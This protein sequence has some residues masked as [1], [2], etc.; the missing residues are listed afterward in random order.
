VFPVQLPNLYKG[1]QL[2]VVGRYQQ[3]DSGQVTLSG[4]NQI[5]AQQYAYPLVL[6]DSFIEGN[7][8]LVKLWAKK[9]IES[10]M[11]DYFALLPDSA[12]ELVKQEVIDIS[13]CYQVVSPFTSLSS[14]TGGNGNTT[15]VEV[16]LDHS[17]SMMSI[18][19]FPN[20]FSDQIQFA[21]TVKEEV[22]DW[23]EIRIFDIQGKL[24]K[25]LKLYMGQR[26]DYVVEWNG[27]DSNGNEVPTGQYLVQAV[28]N[29]ENLTGII[30]KRAR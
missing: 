2:M 20:P 9:K 18:K 28:I 22:K 12:A 23:V 25:T 11:G 4:T 8:F 16:E 24:V 5:N 15:S 29:G 26:G 3:P 10:L 7:K 30:Q 27:N 13:L 19:A 1:R 21:I 17:S 6:T 14:N